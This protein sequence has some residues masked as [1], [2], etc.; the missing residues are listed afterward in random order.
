M[1]W[2]HRSRGRSATGWAPSFYL[3][4]HVK[5][6]G[7]AYPQRQNPLHL[8]P[9]LLFDLN[10]F[11]FVIFIYSFL[12]LW[13]FPFPFSWFSLPRFHFATTTT[14]ER[15]I[16]K[17]FFFF[18]FFL[19]PQLSEYMHTIAISCGTHVIIFSDGNFR[20]EKSRK[21]KPP[22]LSLSQLVFFFSFSNKRHQF[23]ITN[24]VVVVVVVGF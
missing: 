9:V 17:P 13:W 18:F 3:T 6:S 2:A 14:T 12:I 15:L 1:T 5:R 7:A 24:V 20:L 19:F 22:S 10:R 8:C 4:H 11:V 23:V 16:R 21:R